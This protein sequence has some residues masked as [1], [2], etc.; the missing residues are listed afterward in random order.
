MY[1]G[2]G[3]KRD[4]MPT[5]G[6][7][8]KRTRVLNQRMKR[9]VRELIFN[10]ARIHVERNLQT[11]SQHDQSLERHN[12]ITVLEALRNYCPK[13]HTYSYTLGSNFDP[14]S[15]LLRSQFRAELLVS[16]GQVVGRSSGLK[17]RLIT[18]LTLPSFVLVGSTADSQAV[19]NPRH[20]SLYTDIWGWIVAPKEIGDDRWGDACYPFR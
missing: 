8:T 2:S 15:S 18:R 12:P 19:S 20:V 14:L 1:A 11:K 5:C 13:W 7:D 6:T 3:D 9:Y 16:V 4:C 17:A 10:N